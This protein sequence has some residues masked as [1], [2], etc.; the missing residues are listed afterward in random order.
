MDQLYTDSSKKSKMVEHVLH[1]EHSLPTIKCEKSIGGICGD[2]GGSF[3]D[4]L[5]Y[6]EPMAESVFKQPRTNGV[7]HISTHKE[8][9]ELVY[10]R[11]TFKDSS[12]NSSK[13]ETF[14]DA[15]K[16]SSISILRKYGYTILDTISV[17]SSNVKYI[18]CVDSIGSF[19][20]VDVTD[21]DGAAVQLGNQTTVKISQTSSKIEPS[22]KISAIEC[23]KMSTCGVIFNCV[24]EMCSVK[25]NDDGGVESE[26][27]IVTSKTSDIKITPDGSP[28]AFPIITLAEIIA[29]PENAISRVYDVSTNMEFLAVNET[30][31]NLVNVNTQ[32]Q[33][34]DQGV[35]RLV[36]SYTE[37]QR[38][39]SI[40]INK[41]LN[42]V[43]IPIKTTQE[44]DKQ[45]S[46]ED[47]D[48]YTKS[49]KRV[50]DLRTTRSQYLNFA[51]S[52]SSKKAEIDKIVTDTQ[53]SYWAI[54]ADSTKPG[55]SKSVFETD[56]SI[57]VM[58]NS[59][60]GLPKETQG[61]TLPEI[62][63]FLRS[64][65]DEENYKYAD[66]I[67]RVRASFAR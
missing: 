37:L 21:F 5:P 4:R 6:M 14:L 12:E 17:D 49:V 13:D 67:D 61:M 52:F 43:I 58:E 29:D 23:S 60:W 31:S 22:V 3:E 10:E 30:I 16:K 8:Y 48:V 38:A 42:D 53:N 35:K 54:W 32:L 2:E 66:Q 55:T 33:Q 11:P 57:R 39:I 64:S 40:K 59:F 15:I 9:N 46:S 65:E 36:D 28:L 26:N 27:Y 7:E 19:C 44:E 63:K 50:K 18:K 51:N 45:L 1:K 34:L 24:G 20:Y 62:V 41:I 47:Q 56:D 25:M